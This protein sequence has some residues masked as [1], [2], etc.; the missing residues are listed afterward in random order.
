MAVYPVD[1]HE[2]DE[3][4]QASDLAMYR[5]KSCCPAEPS[6]PEPALGEA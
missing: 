4:M 1:G 3:L 2:Y 6:V 5:S